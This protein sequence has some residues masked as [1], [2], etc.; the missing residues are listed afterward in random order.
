MLD[1]GLQALKMPLICWCSGFGLQQVLFI[2]A[3]LEQTINNLQ[4][5]E[6]RS[7]IALMQ[8]FPGLGADIKRF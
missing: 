2:L 6:A 4:N 7:P 1:E 5:V 3:Q 8:T